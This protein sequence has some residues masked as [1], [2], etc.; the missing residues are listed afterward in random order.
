[1]ST[2][3]VFATQILS[4]KH[5]F[6]DNFTKHNFKSVNIFFQHI[7]RS[8]RYF[9][10]NQH[11]HHNLKTYKFFETINQQQQKHEKQRCEY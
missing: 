2:V 4:V 3:V 5:A 8:Y 7:A 1:M 10:S 9:Q 6:G 11:W